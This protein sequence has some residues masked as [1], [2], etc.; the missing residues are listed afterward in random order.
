[1]RITLPVLLVLSLMPLSGCLA[2]AAGA[3]GIGYVR[4]K[5]NEETRD[6]RAELEEVWAAAEEAMGRLGHADP[7]QVSRNATAWVME[8]EAY[9]VRVE[10]HVE[11]TTRLR[12][13]V[14]TFESAEHRREA[15]LIVEEVAVIL[16]QD[17]NIGE[18]SEKVRALSELEP[19]PES[20]PESD[21]N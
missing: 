15:L 11:G 2:V 12:V 17:L 16:T 13:R 3:A 10:R 14:G 5:R 8:G 18:W 7:E 21:G 1:M 20:V 19:K 9:R 6:F 4:Y